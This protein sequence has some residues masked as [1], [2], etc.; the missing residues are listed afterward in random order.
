MPPK[1]QPPTFDFSFLKGELKNSAHTILACTGL[2]TILKEKKEKNH[3]YKLGLM[4]A[5]TLHCS[6][7]VFIP[8]K[9]VNKKPRQRLKCC[10]EK[11]K[12]SL[13][14]LTSADQLHWLGWQNLVAGGWT[15]A[16]RLSQISGFTLEGD[17][18]VWLQRY[19]WDENWYTWGRVL[20]FKE[21]KVGY[22]LV[23]STLQEGFV[24]RR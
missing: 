7:V 9:L 16:P 5:S 22:V 12:N 6:E 20:S 2:V 3:E 18:A 11:K 13:E 21:V 8:P 17:S 14:S 24:A 23:L 19:S 1:K 10:N 4:L 15:E